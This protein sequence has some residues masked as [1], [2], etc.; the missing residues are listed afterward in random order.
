M[1]HKRCFRDDIFEKCVLW[2]KENNDI[3]H[4]INEYIELKELGDKLINELNKLD[5][6]ID[7][8]NT[9]EKIE[10]FYYFRII[11]KKRRKKK[12]NIG[13]KLIKTFIRDMYFKF[14]E[15]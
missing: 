8:L 5:K 13:I 10:Y 2:K 4:I 9:L 6:K 15:A 14:G 12:D 3:K 1:Y 7:K 11:Q